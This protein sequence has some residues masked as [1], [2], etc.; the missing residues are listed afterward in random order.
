MID[1]G[2]CIRAQLFTVCLAVC[3]QLPSFQCL[4]FPVG[5]VHGFLE[6]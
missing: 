6:P 2:V 5:F 4:H 3:I 1:V